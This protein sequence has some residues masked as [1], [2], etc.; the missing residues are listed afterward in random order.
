MIKKKQ[1]QSLKKIGF[2][3]LDHPK[4]QKSTQI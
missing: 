3:I 2:V 1:T 4:K